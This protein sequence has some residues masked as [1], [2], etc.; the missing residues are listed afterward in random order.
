MTGTAMWYLTRGTG[1]VSLLL[2]TA[3]V[4]LG[5][6]NQTRWS[7]DRWPRFALQ[8]LH[9]NVSLVA[10]AVVAVHVSTSVI[11]RFA[12]IGWKDTLVPFLS[13]YR[14]LWLGLGTL[15]AD[16]F[17]AVLITS[18][19]RPRISPRLW[20]AVHWV[21]YASWPAAVLHSLGTGTD[22]KVG[23][24]L[25]LT[26]CCILSVVLAVWWR[27]SVGWPQ[28]LPWRAAG[29]VAS[30]LL[31]IGLTG[32]AFAGPLR[33]GWA[34]T[35]GTPSHLLAGSS[36]T[37]ATTTSVS[38]TLPRLPFQAAFQGRIS[39]STSQDG[40]TVTVS[41]SGLLEGGKQGVLQIAL[42]G[43]ALPEGGISMSDGAGEY[44]TAL[45][46]RIYKGSVASLDGGNIVLHMRAAGLQP[47]TLITQLD[48]GE[49]SSVTGTV[50]GQASN[51]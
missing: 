1:I 12:P 50:A 3:S 9:K 32:F 51:G 37:R 42:R 39:E 8:D 17:L 21:S 41:I 43:I 25:V 49:G 4:V 20:R 30:V 13:P 44:G 38:D 11:D 46:Q 6:V 7:T 10:L 24:M 23:W 2:L 15:S 28:N 16:F 40:S 22:V 45:R 27:V 18:L 36:T 48:I 14:P 33:P 47:M 26:A 34:Q 29:V 31:P 5:V 19:L 35:A